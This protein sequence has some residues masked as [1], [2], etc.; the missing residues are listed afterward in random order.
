MTR[1]T[2]VFLA[3]VLSS[4]P[5]SQLTI[6]MPHSFIFMMTVSHSQE[7]ISVI[8]QYKQSRCNLN[9]SASNKAEFY[10]FLAQVKKWAIEG[11]YELPTKSSRFL[12]SYF[13]LITQSIALAFMLEAYFQTVGKG[14][15]KGMWNASNFLCNRI[16]MYT[17]F[18]LTSC[19]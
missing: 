13:F 6:V 14:G 11:S 3:W 10:F 7:P 5:A 17:S 1:G 4:L 2:D 19:L 18:L 8:I 12:R 16:G 15:E 9:Y